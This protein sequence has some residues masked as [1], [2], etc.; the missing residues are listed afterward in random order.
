MCGFDCVTL[1]I[2]TSYEVIKGETGDAPAGIKSDMKR[3][4]MKTATSYRAV[5]ICNAGNCIET[6]IN[7]DLGPDKNYAAATL[8]PNTADCARNWFACTIE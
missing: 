2:E 6:E 4:P 8:S 3:E 7:E 1:F 5:Y